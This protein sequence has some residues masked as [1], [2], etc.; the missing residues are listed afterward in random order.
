MQIIKD[1]AIVG[2]AWLHLGDDDALPSDG[3]VSVS[4][5]RLK[6]DE[7]ALRARRGGLGV[8][9]KSDEH[10]SD[11]AEYVS[12]LALISV[13]FPKFTDGRGYTI[14]RLLRDRYQYAGE[15]RAVGQ[16]LQDQIFYM[17]R[18]GYNS[19][20]LA[21]GKSLEKALDAFADFSVTYQAAADDAQ[22][23]FRRATR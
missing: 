15:L 6:R 1:R 9:L 10:A 13:E 3:D 18:C 20:Q 21:P 2:D 7:A 14:G 22:P 12:H 11:L 23:V 17:A 4:L 8:R 16:V 19:F 5:A